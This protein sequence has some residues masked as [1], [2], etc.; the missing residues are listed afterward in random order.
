MEGG[1]LLDLIDKIDQ[2]TLYSEMEVCMAISDTYAK[3]AA[4]LSHTEN[5]YLVQESVGDKIKLGAAKVW[6]TIKNIFH[7]I[8]G[9]F[10]KLVDFVK[11][12]FKKRKK[13]GDQIA[14]ELDIKPNSSNSLKDKILIKIERIKNGRASE[15]FT[16]EAVAKSLTVSLNGDDSFTIN[17]KSYGDSSVMDSISEKRTPRPNRNNLHRTQHIQS[18][19]YASSVLWL[20]QDKM[21][22]SFESFFEDFITAIKNDDNNEYHRLE[23]LYRNTFSEYNTRV[24]P[25]DQP[26]KYSKL[27]HIQKTI[28]KIANKFD[29]VRLEEVK[30]IKSDVLTLFMNNLYRD[31][32]DIQMGLNSLYKQLMKCNIVDARYHK[33]IDDIETLGKFVKKSIDAGC[34]PEDIIQNCVILSSDNLMDRNTINE[35][36]GQSRF[37]MFPKDESIVYKLATSGFGLSSN[38]SEYIISN[39]TKHG[40][41]AIRDWIALTY[42]QYNSYS[43][44]SQERCKPGRSASEYREL[45]KNLTTILNTDENKKYDMIDI[46]TGNCGYSNRVNHVVAYDYG[47][48]L[49]KDADP[50]KSMRH[51]DQL[52][53][54]RKRVGSIESS[55]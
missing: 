32:N 22:D 29:E 10:R 30:N 1:Q 37:V 4:I 2:V 14:D 21:I 13:T 24:L 49:R 47:Y 18:A 6:E 33:A 48:L 16:V 25:F 3:H 19:R 40:I 31:L 55:R 5:E 26:I 36:A 46:H 50:H 43:I 28:S 23:K 41:P 39:E 42:D 53:P 34:P 20:F 17:S 27:T 35:S 51:R 38:R 7:F 8:A 15:P 9:L 11:G 52:I 44:I 45:L 54:T 12:L